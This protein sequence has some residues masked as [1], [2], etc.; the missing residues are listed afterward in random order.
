MR[1]YTIYKNGQRKHSKWADACLGCF[2][3]LG[4]EKVNIWS[5]FFQYSLIYDI[6]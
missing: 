4:I 6:I 2:L 5:K 3:R 1:E